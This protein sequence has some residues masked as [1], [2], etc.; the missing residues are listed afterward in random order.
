M[1]VVQDS[2]AAQDGLERAMRALALPATQD[3]SGAAAAVR[4]R[5]ICCRAQVLGQLAPARAA[6]GAHCWRLRAERD[7]A[8]LTLAVANLA[9]TWQPKAVAE[10]AQVG[11][12]KALGLDKHGDLGIGRC[13]VGSR[14][15]AVTEPDTEDVGRD[16]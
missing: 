13:E 3:S 1:L 14:G 10:V 9:Y 15:R 6:T 16:R 8:H 4:A 12:I 5:G 11:D 7:S 2:D